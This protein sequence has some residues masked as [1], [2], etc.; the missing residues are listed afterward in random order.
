[1][2]VVEQSNVGGVLR[3]H[4]GHLRSLDR[5]FW[6]WLYAGTTGVDGV[7]D[8]LTP[9]SPPFENSWTNLGGGFVPLR[10]KLRAPNDPLVDG[11]VDG[12]TIGTVI[13]TWPEVFWPSHELPLDGQTVDGVF[14][15]FR[16]RTNGE[17]Y[18]VA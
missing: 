7:D 6:M 14:A 8:L 13:T 17:F 11:F 2:S 15:A 1:V 5:F 3:A 16:L 10:I 12:G 4:A 18:R 9:E